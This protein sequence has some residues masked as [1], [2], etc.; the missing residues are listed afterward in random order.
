MG[1][2]DWIYGTGWIGYNGRSQNKDKRE[3]ATRISTA[4]CENGNRYDGIKSK[5]CWLALFH[6][7]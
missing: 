3:D 7:C 5:W 4:G 1:G 2:R 6:A